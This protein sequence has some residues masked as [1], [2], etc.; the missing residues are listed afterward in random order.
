MPIARTYTFDNRNLLSPLRVLRIDF[1]EKFIRS[2][3]FRK[4]SKDE[5]NVGDERVGQCVFLTR[6]IVIE[7]LLNERWEDLYIDRLRD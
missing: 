6:R 5:D 2:F 4:I 3:K 1:K 7:S